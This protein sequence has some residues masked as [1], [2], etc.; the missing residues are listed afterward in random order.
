MIKNWGQSGQS[1]GKILYHIGEGSSKRKVKRLD[2][3]IQPLVLDIY[4]DTSGEWSHKYLLILYDFHNLS[5][6]DLFIKH[7]LFPCTKESYSKRKEVPLLRA[8]KVE[9]EVNDFIP[10]CS[11][12]ALARVTCGQS[13]VLRVRVLIVGI[14]KNTLV[15]LLSGCQASTLL[16]NKV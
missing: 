13:F 11:A 14:T 9:Q 1:K 4:I 2:D 7:S 3:R 10:P 6:V 8:E 12:R 16:Q 15:L 5:Y